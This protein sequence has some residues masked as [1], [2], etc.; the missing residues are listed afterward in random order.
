MSAAETL[1]LTYRGNDHY[2]QGDFA[3][4]C[5]RCGLS[6]NEHSF[7][8]L[9]ETMTLDEYRK[10][11]DMSDKPAV[12]RKLHE[13]PRYALD[14]SSLKSAGFED[15]ICVIEFPNGHLFAYSMTP[16]QFEAFARSESKGRHYAK[17]IKGKLAGNKLTGACASCQKQPQVI[18]E[19]CECGGQVM[20]LV[21]KREAERLER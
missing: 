19:T 12:D 1:T 2:Y 14:S 3:K 10:R 7:V 21:S 5:E 18:G 8:M 9:T 6:I 20:A 17:E 4:T 16:E 13:I 11:F 15:D